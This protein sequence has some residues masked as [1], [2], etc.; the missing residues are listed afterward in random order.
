MTFC[1]DK[2]RIEDDSNPHEINPISFNIQ[3]VLQENYHNIVSDNYKV[4][5]RA[6]AKAQTNVPTV[7]KIQ[8]VAQ[9]ATPKIVKLPIKTEKK[10]ILKHCSVE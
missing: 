2:L 9:K 10:M 8:Q 3:E 5:M 7:V 4:Q 6:Q 1:P